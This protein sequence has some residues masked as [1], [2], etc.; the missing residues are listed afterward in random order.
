MKD[1]HEMYVA[2][3][4]EINSMPLPTSPDDP[5]P[6]EEEEYV[7]PEWMKHF[8]TTAPDAF[9]VEYRKALAAQLDPCARFEIAYEKAHEWDT[10]YP[11]YS[12]ALEAGYEDSD[13][14]DPEET[15]EAEWLAPEFGSP[16]RE[17]YKGFNAQMAFIRKCGGSLEVFDDL[18][19]F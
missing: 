9:D 18:W 17:W 11:D 16:R 8:G 19:E 10:L 12:P 14:P 1:L 13:Q 4:A 3:Y 6:V 15:D 5:E 7:E 2:L